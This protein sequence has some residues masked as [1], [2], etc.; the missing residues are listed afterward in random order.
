MSIITVRFLF[1][2]LLL[3]EVS[4]NWSN[5]NIFGQIGQIHGLDDTK[6]TLFPVSPKIKKK[7]W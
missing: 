2:A 7:S 1:G 4:S 5:F 6:N 3:T